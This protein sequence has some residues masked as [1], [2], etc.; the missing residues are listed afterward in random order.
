[1]NIRK[2]MTLHE[3]RVREALNGGEARSLAGLSETHGRMIR[4]MQHERLIH[5]LV[6]LAVAA[7]FLASLVLAWIRPSLPSLLLAGLFSVLLVPYI[8][9][10]YF[11]E[12]AV[13][14]WYALADEIEARRQSR[15]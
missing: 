1:M 9:H 13:Q 8:F 7:F 5:L 6:L 14:R 15:V 11:L 12:N 2:Y 4:F 10:Y 3:A